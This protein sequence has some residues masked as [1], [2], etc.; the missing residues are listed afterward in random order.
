MINALYLLAVAS[1]NSS[2]NRTSKQT[3]YEP[4]KSTK[5]KIRELALTR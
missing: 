3:V 2:A 5:T 4:E 1:L